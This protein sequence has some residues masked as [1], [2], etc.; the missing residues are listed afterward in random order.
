MPLS[1]QNCFSAKALKLFTVIVTALTCL[2]PS[3]SGAQGNLL[4]T[5]RRV[6]FDKPPYVRELNLANIGKD[7]ARYLV[8]MMEIRMKDDGSFEQITVPDSGQLF[9]SKNLRVYPRSV[10][11]PPGESQ[12]VKVQLVKASELAPGEYRSHVYIRAVP[13]EKPLGD[14]LGQKTSSDI[15]V[16][17]TAIFGISVP[18]IVRVGDYDTKVSISDPSFIMMDDKTPK[19]SLTLNR[20]GMMSSYGDLT[21]E[22]IAQDGTTKQVGVVRGI[23]VYTPGLKRRFQMD[24]DNTQK[25]DY[26]NCK[27]HIVYKTQKDASVQDFAE[28]DLALH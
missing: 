13:T 18:A 5:P 21:V 15:S 14:T 24:L 28:A 22:C 23:A 6:V 25:V 11:I 4:V 7:T 2:T 16:K 9:A 17:L 27:L 20:S 1:A 3:S 10:T 19:L 8:S 12:V 26:H